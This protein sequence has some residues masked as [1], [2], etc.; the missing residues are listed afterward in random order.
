[1][2]YKLIKELF[3]A[4]KNALELTNSSVHSPSLYTMLCRLSPRLLAF[5]ALP[6]AVRGLAYVD[7]PK[8]EFSFGVTWSQHNPVGISREMF[9]INGQSPGPVIEVDQGDWVVVR[10]QNDSPFNVTIHFHGRY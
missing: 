6:Y 2:N 5:L 4:A 3:P 1:M 9:L 10:V 8:K 7:G